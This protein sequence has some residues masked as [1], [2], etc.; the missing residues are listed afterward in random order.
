MQLKHNILILEP[1]RTKKAP[2]AQQPV[3]AATGLGMVYVFNC[4]PVTISAIS[5]NGTALSE[6]PSGSDPGQPPQFVSVNR[7]GA[8]PVFGPS[9]SFQLTF[10][11]ESNYGQTIVINQPA[12]ASLTLLCFY[13]GFVLADPYGTILQ[14]SWGL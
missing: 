10:I 11:D 6:L 9:T 2:N 4:T 8:P 1:A 3:V 7:F 5:V 12:P 13:T 14:L